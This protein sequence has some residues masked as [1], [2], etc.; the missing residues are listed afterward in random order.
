MKTTLHDEVERAALVADQ[1]KYLM[2]YYVFIWRLCCMLWPD[3][4]K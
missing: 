2:T 4:Y 1:G 3:E